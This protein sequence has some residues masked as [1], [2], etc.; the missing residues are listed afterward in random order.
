MGTWRAAA[1]TATAKISNRSPSS[2]RASG[3]WAA[4]YASNTPTVRAMVRATGSPGSSSEKMGSRA[5]RQG[6]AT[7]SA[8]ISATVAPSRAHRCA[9][10]ATSAG[11]GPFW[12]SFATTGRSRPNS[13]RVEVT[14]VMAGL[15]IG[16]SCF[17][18]V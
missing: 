10:V 16:C 15:R 2:T 13:A 12:Q 3:R 5:A 8:S 4:K 6:A 18:R 9:P 7:G 11:A 1:A 14:T 17:L